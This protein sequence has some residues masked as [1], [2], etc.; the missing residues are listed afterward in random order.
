MLTQAPQNAEQIEICGP[1]CLYYWIRLEEKAVVPC[2]LSQLLHH[3]L[4]T[5]LPT[6]WFGRRTMNCQ[7]QM[8]KC[9]VACCCLLLLMAMS[10]KPTFG[11]LPNEPPALFPLSSGPS[12]SPQGACR[13]TT[14]ANA[15]LCAS[16]EGWDRVYGG[17]VFFLPSYWPSSMRP[18]CTYSL[19]PS[20]Q[21]HTTTTQSQLSQ[22]LRAANH[23]RPRKP[24]PSP[25]PSPR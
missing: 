9:F 8:R 21:T 16:P 11:T 13:L 24:A 18:N 23:F 4:P 7:P 25:C 22:D 3:S 6:T 10:C 20:T 17:T 1:T 15:T 5:I 12:L 14:L 2:P 19:P